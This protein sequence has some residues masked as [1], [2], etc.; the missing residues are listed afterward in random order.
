MKWAGSWGDTEHLGR[1]ASSPAWQ[2]VR[3]DLPAQGWGAG[4]LTSSSCSGPTQVFRSLAML[5]EAD[6][7]VDS[8]LPPMSTNDR[9]LFAWPSAPAQLITSHTWS[10]G[11]GRE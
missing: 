11:R 7:P 1:A 4:L 10:L 9:F 5:T 6:L 8:T 2:G 3:W